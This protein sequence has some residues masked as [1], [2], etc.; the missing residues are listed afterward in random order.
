[1]LRSLAHEGSIF[2]KKG[3]LVDK[4]SRGLPFNGAKSA[5]KLSKLVPLTL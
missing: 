3:G 4:G 5:L 2:E 1:M